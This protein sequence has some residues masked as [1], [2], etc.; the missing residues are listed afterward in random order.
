M[1][2]EEQIKKMQEELKCREVVKAMEN[3]NVYL[4]GSDA[5]TVASLHDIVYNQLG[6]TTG[7][8]TV[9]LEAIGIL[10]SGGYEQ[11]ELIDLASSED[12]TTLLY[13]E[14][15]RICKEI[16]T[17]NETLDEHGWDQAISLGVIS[18]TTHYA[19]IPDGNGGYKYDVQNIKPLT[20]NRNGLASGISGSIVA[21][22]VDIGTLTQ[23][24]VITEKGISNVNTTI[25]SR[26]T[27]K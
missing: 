12:K 22:K 1:Y 10:Y 24:Q 15:I 25:Q 8:D 17:R 3:Q 16:K 9:I 26:F 21:G 5:M 4:T 19:L 6:P 13:R 11:D 2:S 27:I 7:L 14:L 20:C 18:G 23:T